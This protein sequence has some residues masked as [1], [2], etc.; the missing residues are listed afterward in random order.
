M[1]VSGERLFFWFIFELKDEVSM[2]SR[3][4]EVIGGAVGKVGFEL[5]KV[6]G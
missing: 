6:D 2:V 3:D 4:S 5:W 1:W